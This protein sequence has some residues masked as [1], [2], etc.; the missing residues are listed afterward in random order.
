MRSFIALLLAVLLWGCGSAPTFAPN[1]GETACQHYKRVLQEIA[2]GQ[3]PLPWWP[4]SAREYEWRLNALRKA[5]EL[6]A[7]VE[8]ADRQQN[9]RQYERP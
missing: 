9:E 4:S 5:A 6:E 2:E 3:H 8:A 1:P 7:L